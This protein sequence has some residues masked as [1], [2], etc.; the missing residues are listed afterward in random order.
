[1]TTDLI[2]KEITPS[3]VFVPNGL[4]M[5][6]AGVEAKLK[7]EM[8]KQF[9]VNDETDRKKRAS[10][11]YQITRSKTFVDE[12]G[13][14]YVGELKVRTKEIDAERK[15]FRDQMDIF[16]DEAKA[17]ITTWENAEKARI[18]A[19]R[20]L[21]IFLMDWDEALEIESLFAR[22]RAIA[23][24]EAAFAKAEEEK[25][26]K[27]EADRKAK[28][29]AEREE[30]LKKEAAEQA[31]RE[32]QAK[33]AQEREES[34]RKEREARE[35]IEQAERDRVALEERMK[36]EKEQAEL[37]KIEAAK[38][39]EID[40]QE[41]VELA[42]RQAEERARIEQEDKDKVAMLAKQTADKKAANKRHQAGINN[43]IVAALIAMAIAIPEEA[44]K[45]IVIAIA[46]GKIPNVTINY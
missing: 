8:E 1:M 2:P 12:K 45:E 38:Q 42:Q 3:D 15:K 36:L 27:E 40:K 32:E 41:A 6:I 26:H 19:E 31:K 23:E 29:Q 7:T 28:E 44:A 10:F 43:K 35:S 11:A 34:A 24:K 30:R 4:D 33:I 37:A 25:R 22:E 16:R 39:A 5:I 13:K 46:Q 21:E 9:D 17:P 14:A 20:K 18:K